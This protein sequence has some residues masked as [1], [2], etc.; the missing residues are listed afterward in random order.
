MNFAPFVRYVVVPIVISFSFSI[1]ISVDAQNILLRN[2]NYYINTQ[3][4]S[5]PN[6]INLKT[7]ASYFDYFIQSKI[8]IWD[9]LSIKANTYLALDQNFSINPEELYVSIQT[10]QGLF[11]DYG[12]KKIAWGKSFGWNIFNIFDSNNKFQTFRLNYDNYSNIEWFMNKDLAISYIEDIDINSKA[13]KV[14]SSIFD[15]DI[16]LAA[17]RQNDINS[18]GITGA[19]NIGED[20]VAYFEAVAKGVNNLYYPQYLGSDIYVWGNKN[21]NFW[22]QYLIGCQY[23]TP[24]NYNLF[25]EYFYNS[26]GLDDNDVDAY[27]KGIEASLSGGKYLNDSPYKAF[28]FN[29]L[30][31]YQFNKF[32]RNYLFFMISKDEILPNIS[33]STATYYSIDEK[34]MLVLPNLEYR[35]NNYSLL[36][37]L[38]YIPVGAN[39]SEYRRFYNLYIQTTLK[40]EF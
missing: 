34:C 4:P 37:C 25:F 22:P 9:G 7:H 20:L 23:T 17:F 3:S 13:I 39:D 38:F 36:S 26:L 32:R 35:I 31:Y 29:N 24:E 33:L 21:S 6:L 12:K 18:L 40:I 16:D 15:C 10:L 8:N 1:D 5:N 19:K 2:W 28:M 11:W 30:S 14:H 27:N